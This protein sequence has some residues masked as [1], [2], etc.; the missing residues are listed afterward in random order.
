MKIGKMDTEIN[1]ESLSKCRSIVK[2]I[3]KFGVNEQQ[4][5]DIIYFLTLELENRVLIENISQIIKKHRTVIK[6]EQNTEYGN[7]IQDLS[8]SKDNKLLGV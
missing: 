7:D 6:P 4:K 5:I 2:E 1:V 3:I 8:S